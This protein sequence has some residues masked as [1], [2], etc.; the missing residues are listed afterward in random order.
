MANPSSDDDETPL[1]PSLLRV[2]ARLRR[3][4]LIAGL[5]LGLGI[6][7]VFGAILYKI[8]TAGDR[9]PAG[10]TATI[11]AATLPAGARLV[12]SAVVG[13]RVVLTYE[14]PA[15]TTLVFIDAKTLAVA[16]RV[17]LK[18]GQEGAGAPVAVPG[19]P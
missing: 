8:A 1:D 14:H 13:N 10:G 9:P 4:M 6:F 19:A 12:S 17:D 11:A 2:Q 15:G 18:A 5:T 7:A 16:G 3:L